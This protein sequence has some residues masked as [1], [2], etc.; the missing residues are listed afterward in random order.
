MFLKAAW[1]NYQPCTFLLCIQ[2]APKCLSLV[3]IF[4]HCRNIAEAVFSFLPDSE[5]TAYAMLA[6]SPLFS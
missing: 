1:K 3:L 2:R 5:V 4:L 6:M